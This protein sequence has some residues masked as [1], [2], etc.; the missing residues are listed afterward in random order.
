MR[1]GWIGASWYARQCYGIHKVLV[2]HRLSWLLLPRWRPLHRKRL[3]LR[4]HN[5]RRRRLRQQLEW[6]WDPDCQLRF[7]GWLWY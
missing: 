2:S 5:L 7:A 6:H 1:V 3:R 4:L